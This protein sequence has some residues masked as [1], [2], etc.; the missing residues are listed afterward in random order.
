MNSYFYRTAIILLSVIALAIGASLFYWKHLRGILPGVTEPSIG[1]ER[2][3]EETFLDLPAGFSLKIF[4]DNLP[5][6]RM[7][8][9]DE[10]GDMWVSQTKKGRISKITIRDGNALRTETM[11]EKLQKPHGIAFDPN[12][13]S[14]LYVAEEH[15]LS[16]INLNSREKEFENLMPMPN[17]GGH[18]TR[19]IRFG[20]D[21]RLYLSVGSSCNV[22]HENNNIRASIL[23]IGRGVGDTKT[24]A[25]GLRN[26]VFFTWHPN[27]NEMWATEMGRD[28]LGDDTPPDEINIIKEG[29]FYG[30]PICY[31]KNIHDIDFDKNVY[32]RNPC[33]APFETPSYINIPAHSSPLGLAFVP[34][35]SGWP[36]KY[37]Y[38]LIVAYHGSWNRTV[39]TGYKLVNVVLNKEGVYTNTEDFVSGWLSSDKKEVFGR[40]VDV[41]FRGN[42]LYVSDDKAGVIYQIIYKK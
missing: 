20:P 33:Q 18:F 2:V 16:R 12:N 13:P 29:G 34:P 22:C 3:V 25:T 15:M 10:F 36:E 39:P 41:V 24:V 32:V 26:S 17:D 4:A 28:L 23:S 9:F 14:V 38:N 1:I 5:E 11:F 30:W 40:P 37:W 19:T 7:M 35:D 27:T 21:E 42:A 6:A 31:G 8:T